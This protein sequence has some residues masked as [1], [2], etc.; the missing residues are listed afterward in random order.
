LLGKW[1]VNRLSRLSGKCAFSVTVIGW[2]ISFFLKQTNQISSNMLH[3][4]EA[5]MAGSIENY[6][7]LLEFLRETLREN[8]PKVFN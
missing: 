3:L 5:G 7:T 6:E 8:A 2:P 4:Q 1:Q